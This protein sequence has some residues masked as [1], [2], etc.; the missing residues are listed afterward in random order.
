MK[1]DEK[2]HI[3]NKLTKARKKLNVLNAELWELEMY[4]KAKLE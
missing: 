2:E 1:Q 3:T 4:V